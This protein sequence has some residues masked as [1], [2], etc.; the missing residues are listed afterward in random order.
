MKKKTS[1]GAEDQARVDAYLRSALHNR[2][3][4]PFR[5]W[6]LLGCIVLLMTGLSLFSYFLAYQ[7][8]VV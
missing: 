7:Y 4:K 1:L 3:R 6:L 2:Q 5:P 8:G